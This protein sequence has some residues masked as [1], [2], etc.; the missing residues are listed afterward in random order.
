M[1]MH[2]TGPRVIGP[3]DPGLSGSAV[4][5]ADW[6]P[7][8]AAPTFAAM[9]LLNFVLGGTPD[10]LCS[11]TQAVSPLGSMTAMYLLMSASHAAPWLKRVSATLRS[12]AP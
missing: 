8:A 3:S 4:S 2:I 6:L 10:P 9:A 7:F 12:E 5:L 11:A 1:T